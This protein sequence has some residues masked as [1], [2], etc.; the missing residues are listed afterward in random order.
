MVRSPSCDACVLA[1]K[2]YRAPEHRLFHRDAGYLEGR[3]VRRS[4]EMRAM[5]TR[6]AFGRSLLAD[7]WAAAEFGALTRLW[8]AGAPVPY[9]V[10]RDGTELLLEFVGDPDGTAAPRL[11]QLRPDHD[12]LAGLWEQ[13]VDAL[14]LLAGQGLAHGDLSAFNLLVH[15][16]R[17]VV[18][19]LPQV[20][21]VVANPGGPELLARD[22]R[23]VSTWFAGRGLPGGLVDPDALLARLL[24]RAW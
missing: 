6:T 13:L 22:V 3:R 14:L 15:R 2:R 19:D 21:D 4:R 1:A 8:P 5:S 17:L 16:G 23:N 7:Q 10:Q 24:A 18:I 11:A 20:V 12:E 9:P